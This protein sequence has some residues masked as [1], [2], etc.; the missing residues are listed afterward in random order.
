MFQQSTL[1]FLK[2]L[3]KNNNKIWFDGH[4]DNYLAAK[5]DYAGFVSSLIKRVAVFDPEIK[6]LEAKDCTFRINRD[7]RF[8]KDKTPYKVNMGASLNKG[9][10]KSIYAGYYFHLEPGNKSFAG[11]GLWMP[12]APELKKV[13]QE[14]DYNFDEFNGI[15]KDKKFIAHFRAVD[16]SDDVKLVNV[17][18]GYEKTNPAADYLKL[19]SFIA[20]KNITDAEL[21]MP[22]LL[23]EACKAFEA[24]KPFIAFLNQAMV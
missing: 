19:K 4:R 20:I 15:L 21:K 14:I 1:L 3:A 6:D 12:M 5:N 8:S 24:L 13:R 11:G 10:K 2:S 9:G 16:T 18:R 17:P 7:I 23:T 22:S